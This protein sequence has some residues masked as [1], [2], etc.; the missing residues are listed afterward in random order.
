MGSWASIPV[1]DREINRASYFI[2]GSTRHEEIHGLERVGG[3]GRTGCGGGKCILSWWQLV[4]RGAWNAHKPV[5]S[6][7]DPAQTFRWWHFNFESLA[8][9]MMC[10]VDHLTYNYIHIKCMLWM[11]YFYNVHLCSYI[12]ILYYKIIIFK[13]FSTELNWTH[14]VITDELE[15]GLSNW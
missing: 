3:W 1:L 8:P 2:N 6:W 7:A 9:I 13:F 4:F 15:W 12:N 5:Y 14:G 10:G 11:S